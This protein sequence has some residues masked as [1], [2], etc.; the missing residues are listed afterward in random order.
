MSACQLLRWSAL[1]PSVRPVRPSTKGPLGAGLFA[2][3]VVQELRVRVEIERTDRVVVVETRRNP[4]APRRGVCIGSSGREDPSCRA[5][6]GNILIVRH[7]VD[8]HHGRFP[9]ENQGVGAEYGSE[10]LGCRGL[11]LAHVA[12][13]VTNDFLW[14]VRAKKGIQLLFV[15]FPRVLGHEESGRRPSASTTRSDRCSGASR[16][17]EYS[18]CRAQPDAP[19]TVFKLRP[20]SWMS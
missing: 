7:V 19:R 2:A 18:P 11:K 10:H 12:F 4:V 14:L 15:W 6:E 5:L 8:M 3:D 9:C 17:S 20:T 16:R 13:N 1:K